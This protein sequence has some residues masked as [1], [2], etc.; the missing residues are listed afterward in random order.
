[1]NPTS[2]DSLSRFSQSCGAGSV[3]LNFLGDAGNVVEKRLFDAPFMVVGRSPDSDLRL[4]HDQV[5][6]RHCYLQV[7]GGLLVVVDLHSQ[8]GILI[9]GVPQRISWVTSANRLQIGPFAFQFQGRDEEVLGAVSGGG[10]LPH[11]NPLSAQYARNLP[12]AGWE[13]EGGEGPTYGWRM[14]RSMALIGRSTGCQVRLM[15]SSI[16]KF[17]AALVR[18]PSGVW[19]VDLLSREGVE[20][21]GAN[22][23]VAQLDEGSVCRVG[24]FTLRFCRGTLA[25]APPR[26]PERSR[27]L[28]SPSPSLAQDANVGQ[29]LG[30]EGRSVLL[31][32]PGGEAPLVPTWSPNPSGN[33]PELNPS[34]N[35]A[36]PGFGPSQEAMMMLAQMLGTMHRD[37]MS[38]VKDELAEIRKLAEEMHALRV[39]IAQRGAGAPA[40]AATPALG[41]A[42]TKATSPT[43]AAQATPVGAAG[44]A[45]SGPKRDEMAPP[46][47]RDPRECLT[48]ASQFLA[49]YEQKQE[50][51][52]SRILR[53]V[54]GISRT[55]EPGRGPLE[56]APFG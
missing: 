2:I 24:S 4:E 16:S 40:P 56:Q 39:E 14:G 35:P 48:I 28:P 47:P 44:T 54:T 45:D 36:E 53:L 18:T 31:A 26:R 19:I 7:I 43:R 9:D 20:V 22:V 55:Q 50:G 41:P 30:P 13:I 5:S 3:H 17:H 23:R 32:N 11:P 29:G 51:H 34:W 6:W 15:H 38:L 46:L 25:P 12:P 37:H 42:A 27:S 10:T 8:G 1:M 21:D 33:G 49:S 52:W